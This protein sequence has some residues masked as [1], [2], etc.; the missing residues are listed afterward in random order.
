M[1][2]SKSILGKFKFWSL[3]NF[4][5]CGV[6]AFPTKQKKLTVETKKREQE[7]SSPSTKPSGGSKIKLKNVENPLHAAVAAE[8][9][10]TI[11][12][13]IKKGSTLKI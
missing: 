5:L 7:M 1:S 10:E 11:V 9:L 13:L 4:P 12:Q 3:Q 6:L 8:D 2:Q